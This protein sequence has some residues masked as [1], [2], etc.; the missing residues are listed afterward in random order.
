MRT[1]EEILAEIERLKDIK[2]RVIP[3]TLFGDDNRIAVQVQIKVLEEGMDEDE[4]YDSYPG[5]W[6]TSHA[7]NAWSWR[8]EVDW[9]GEG[10]LAD[11]WE[12]LCEEEEDD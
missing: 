12:P 10:S 8:E 5:E 4:I 2:K 11:D 6:Q 1:D 7:L 9:E 3:E